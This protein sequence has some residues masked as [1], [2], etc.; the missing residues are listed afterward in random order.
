M[1][2]LWEETKM[3]AF[4][5]GREG[6]FGMGMGTFSGLSLGAEVLTRFGLL[7]FFLRAAILACCFSLRRAR[8]GLGLR[9]PRGEM[10]TDGVSVVGRAELEEPA[11]LLATADGEM[12]EEPEMLKAAELL[13]LL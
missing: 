1:V 9:R 8:K 2:C 10:T 4:P 5:P 11:P 6:R 12:D 7:P 3:G 13:N